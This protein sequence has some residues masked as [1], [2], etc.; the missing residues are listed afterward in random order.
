MNS[1]V[2]RL[3]EKVAFLEEALGKV[4]K[5]VEQLNF[6]MLSLRQDLHS[7]RRQTSPVD[8]A[9]SNTSEQPPRY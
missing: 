4:E 7:V 3:E 5:T 2:V 9:R 6:Q 8:D 1:R